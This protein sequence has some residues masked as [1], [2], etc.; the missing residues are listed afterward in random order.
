[1]AII[2]NH[3]FNIYFIF[4]FRNFTGNSKSELAN[5]F[6]IK[7]SLEIKSLFCE[8]SY[9][10]SNILFLVYIHTTYVCTYRI[11]VIN[12]TMVKSSNEIK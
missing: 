7:D 2:C 9:E 5:L 4:K 12:C 10:I 3:D 8:Q 11:V 1:M 6:S